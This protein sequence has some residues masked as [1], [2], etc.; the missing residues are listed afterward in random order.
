MGLIDINCYK[1]G[2][3]NGFSDALAGKS[4]SYTGFPKG[5]AAIS[6]HCYDTYCNGYNDGYKDGLAKKNEVYK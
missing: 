3:S 1:E 4:K 5:K 6:S 2:Y